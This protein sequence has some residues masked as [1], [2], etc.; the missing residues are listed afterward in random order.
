MSIEWCLLGDGGKGEAFPALYEIWNRKNFRS[1]HLIL[2][3]Q[4]LQSSLSEL[5]FKKRISKFVEYFKYS[6]VA[7][8]TLLKSLSVMGNSLDIF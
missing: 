1:K 4:K 2:C 5:L 3:D 8:R 7:L 6:E